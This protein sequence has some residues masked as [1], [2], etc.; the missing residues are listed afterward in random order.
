VCLPALVGLATLTGALLALCRLRRPELAVLAS[1][2]HALLV[3]S[4]PHGVGQFLSRLGEVVVSR[5]TVDHPVNEVQLH[6]RCSGPFPDAAQPTED[7]RRTDVG[8]PLGGERR[9]RWVPLAATLVFG[10][11][12][13]LAKPLAPLGL[14]TVPVVV[15]LELVVLDVLGDILLALGHAIPRFCSANGCWC[16]HPDSTVS[17]CLTTM[18]RRA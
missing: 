4:M 18:Q 15:E 1:L 6:Q 17:L 13:C 12:P 11:P 14:A 7:S 8:S 2:A 5:R 16:C 9:P 10:D 3:A